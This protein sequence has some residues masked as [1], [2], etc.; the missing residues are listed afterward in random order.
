MSLL[1]DVLSALD[2]WDEWKAMRAAPECVTDLE[3]RVKALEDELRDSSD[4]NCCEHCGSRNIRRTG[5]RVRND[6]M[7]MLG[8]R[9]TRYECQEEK[10]GKESWI[11]D[12]S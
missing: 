2:R 5:S 9:E 1:S 12:K 6:P 7:G 8:A 3:R 10:C 4:G 11:I